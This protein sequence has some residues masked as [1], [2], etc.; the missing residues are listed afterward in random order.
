MRWTTPLLPVLIACSGDG[1]DGT[2]TD[3]LAE[4]CY[5]VAEGTIVDAGPSPE[6]AT[7]L[8]PGPDPYRIGL[9]PDQVSYVKV[10]SGAGT[11]LLMTG[12]VGVVT[13]LAT[14]GDPVAL[15]EPTENPT[16]GQDIPEVF[17]VTVSGGEQLIGLGPHYKATVWL[18]V[19]SP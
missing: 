13:E 5:H 19:S 10:Q 16:C 8:E 2:P 18:L 14:D 3:P 4:G 12:D 6:E 17:Q 7:V 11:L 1:E 15:P 9:Y